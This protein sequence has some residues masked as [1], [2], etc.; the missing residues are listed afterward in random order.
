MKKLIL[1]LALS[2]A[3]LVA[4]NN[5]YAASIAVDNSPPYFQTAALA[6]YNSKGSDAAGMEV[7]AYFSDGS[8]SKALWGATTG[9]VGSGWSLTMD[10][11]SKST[12]PSNSDPGALWSL[13]VTGNLLLDKIVING[14]PGGTIFDYIPTPILTPGSAFGHPMDWTSNQGIATNTDFVAT[15]STPVKLDADSAPWYD[16]YATLTIDFDNA[17][18]FSKNDVLKFYADTDNIANS[19]VP[20]PITLVLFGSGLL[21]LAGSRRIVRRKK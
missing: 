4:S 15:Y 7:T 14:Q 3:A 10:D 9:A 21:G 20:E 1:S 13:A 17:H 12:F 6:G 16:T 18:Y 2:T 11:Y 5:G 8:S 19:P